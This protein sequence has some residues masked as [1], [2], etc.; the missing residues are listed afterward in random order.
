MTSKESYKLQI[1]QVLR[2][3]R[4]SEDPEEY[5]DGLLNFRR[6]A[7]FPNSGAFQ[8]ERGINTPAIVKGS[9]GIE[10]RPAILIASSPHKKGT[11]E[12]P[13]Q[14]FFDVDNGHIRY[15]GDNK[16]PGSDPASSPG[17]KA[18][19]H[20]FQLAHSHEKELRAQTPPML[21]F[22][23]VTHGGKSKGFPQF[24]GFGVIRSAELV[25]QWDNKAERSFTNYAFDFTVLNMQAEHEVFD[26][27]WIQSR[28][29]ESLTLKESNRRGPSSWQKWIAA[30]ANSLDLLRRRVSKLS[31]ESPENQKPTPGTDLFDV[32]QQIYSYYAD[33]KHKFE[34]LAEIVAERVIGNNLGI[35]RKGWVTAA[36]SDGGADFVASIELGSEFSSAKLI[37]LGQAKC[38]SP[39]TATGGNHIARTVA[40][41]KRGWLGV[42]VTTSYFSAPVQQ[43]VIEDRYPI[44]LIPGKRVA[45]EVSEIVYE[46]DNYESV[47]Q[48]LDEVTSE[49]DSRIRQRQPEEILY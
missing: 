2:Y 39:T 20:A 44:V 12:T 38:E 47:K 27:N 18:L 15:Y 19:L 21:F 26:W 7:K 17:N 43:E 37:V 3:P 5:I 48:F 24:L 33:K 16:K 4:A 25:T 35:Y 46:S 40:R 1:G 6:I 34:A 22:R 42:Y 29:D 9:D 32:L 28:R 31:I 8:L 23:R 30:G 11:S 41:L 45:K 14:D 49:Y 36:G 13:W 10:R